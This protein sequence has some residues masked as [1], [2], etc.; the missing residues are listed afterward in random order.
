[1]KTLLIGLA[2]AGL[3]GIGTAR[4]DQPATKSSTTQSRSTASSTSQSPSSTTSSSAQAGTASASKELS[5]VVKD[6][7]KDKHS[8]KISS[9]TGA[10]Q[11]LKVA[12]SAKIT[13]DGSK[14]SLDQ[15][16]EGDQVRASFDASGSQA[17]T[18]EVN[19]KDKMKTDHKDKS[20]KSDT[21]SE[22]KK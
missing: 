8:L 16:K 13:R 12:D 18:I 15:I 6:V 19:S 22:S 9:P 20:E 5:G 21:K 3:V 2:A 11:E 14:A 17:S 1:M 4:A 7:D 10:D